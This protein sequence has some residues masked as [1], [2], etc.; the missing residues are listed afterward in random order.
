M[1]EY[2][3]CRASATFRSWVVTGNA[4]SEE[5][6]QLLQE[7]LRSFERRDFSRAAELLQPCAAAGMIRAQLL[8]SRLYYAGNGVEQDMN[9]YAYWLEQAALQGDRAARAKLKRLRSRQSVV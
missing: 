9:R 1:T 3:C 7:A 4:V 8:L 5:L 2:H 6:Q